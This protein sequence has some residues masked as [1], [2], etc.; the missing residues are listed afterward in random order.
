MTIIEPAEER[1]WQDVVE[2]HHAFS[3]ALRELFSKANDPIQIIKRELL[4][5]QRTTALYIVKSLD[6][7]GIRD[8]V[9]ELVFLSSFAHGG[10]DTARAALLRLPRE[11]L[12]GNI[13]AISEQILQSGTW[14]EYRRML[15]LYETFD[16]DLTLRLARR[17]ARNADPDIREAGMD[18]LTK[19]GASIDE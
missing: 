5:P 19:L 14:D 1:L 3:S 4:G 6:L 8:C 11:Y 15:E 9:R 12:V 17:A 7:K 16:M 18:F 13:P 2:A 10:I